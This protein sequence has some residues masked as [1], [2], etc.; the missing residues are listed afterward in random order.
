MNNQ[1]EFMSDNVQITAII[2]VAACFISFFYFLSK[3]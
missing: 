3:D 1:V 2:C